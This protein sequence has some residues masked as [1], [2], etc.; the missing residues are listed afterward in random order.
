MVFRYDAKEAF[1]VVDGSARKCAEPSTGAKKM[2]MKILS[3]HKC[4]ILEH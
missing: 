4:M 3:G 1:L 2:Y